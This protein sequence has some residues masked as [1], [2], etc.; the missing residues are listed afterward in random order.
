MWSL[1][2]QYRA[3]WVTLVLL[4]APL[5][6]YITHAKQ[7]RELTQLD[8]WVLA[9]TGPIESTLDM[10][11]DVM[12]RHWTEYVDLRHVREQNVELRGRVLHLEGEVLELEEQRLE[13]ERLRQMLDFSRGQ[14]TTTVA[15]HVVGV[16]LSNVFRSL[17]IDRGAVHGV[18]K[19]AAVVT[20]LGVV[21]RI[22][23]VGE[24]YAEV[25]LLDDLNSRVAVQVQRTRARATV[26]GAGDGRNCLLELAERSGLFDDGDLLVTSGTDGIFPKGLAVGRV[27]HLDRKRSG[28]Y[29]VAEVAPLVN[30][31]DV[32]ELVVLGP[33][34][35]PTTLPNAALTP[36]LARPPEAPRPNPE[37]PR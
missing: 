4:A 11:V 35:E 5:V 13:N 36:E 2:K 16:G 37:L 23:E 33:P 28:W 19:G 22:Q 10:A 6:T 32:E 30:L 21:G 7:G 24:S 14:T 34:S 9:A 15:A 29:L 20:P 12:E 26:R 8:E 1:L 31:E 27:T 18:K 3:L 25:L 17:R